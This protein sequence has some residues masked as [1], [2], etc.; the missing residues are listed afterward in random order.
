MS[1]KTISTQSNLTTKPHYLL[2][3]GLRGVAA[4]MV[5]WYHIFEGLATSP[6]DQKFNHGYL[7]V[8]FFFILSGFV[9]GYAYD[10]RW[11]IMN[12]KDFAK[13]RI[14][15]LH[16][17]VV[18]GAAI[19]LISYLIQG[20]ITWEGEK[21]APFSIALA[22]L[23]N[24]FLIPLLPSLDIRGYGEMFPLNGPNWSL[25]FEYIGSF[26]Y[27]LI[28]RKLSTRAL[29]IVVALSGLGLCSF[30]V[31]NL[32]GNA[33][34]GVGWTLAE[35]NFLGGFL[36]VMFSFSAGLLLSRVC[37]PHAIKG[38]FWIC[39]LVLIALL[40]MPYISETHIW[41]NGLY[42][43]VCVIFIFPILVYLGASGQVSNN[44]T[45]KV[46]KFLGDLSYPLYMV[47]Y[48]FMYLF[49][50]WL[51]DGERSTAQIGQII[52]IL[53]LGNILLAYLV[54][55]FYDVPVRKYLTQKF[56]RK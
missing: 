39:S 38:A 54:F 14:I 30:A 42:D 43:A 16:P 4:I 26:L 36:R 55:K 41:L 45:S 52:P 6:V 56:L 27:A 47:H 48:P 18:M 49:Y 11:K 44:F 12:F 33:H 21:V 8:D 29:A 7:A 10:D 15:R 40:S 9:I 25:F 24:L 46:Y 13:R 31:F 23:L 53:F 22:F 37:K 5:V 35:Y 50:A 19:G 32:S 28:L 51:W 20:G 17:L 1:E 2:L 34:L 3:D